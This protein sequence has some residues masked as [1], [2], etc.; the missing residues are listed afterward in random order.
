MESANSG[1]YDYTVGHAKLYGSLAIEGTT[2]QIGFDAVRELLGDI[3]GQVFLD[4]GCGTGR[5]AAF[6]K[7]LGARHV[8]GVDHDQ[9]MISQAQSRELGGVTLMHIDGP[10]PLADA[11]VDGAVSLNVFMEMRTL[12][13]MTRACTEIART[14]RPGSPLIV[15]STSP[16][17]FGHVFRN[18][19]YPVVGPLHSGDTTPCIV[20]TP[21]GQLTIEDTYWTEDDYTGALV[22]AGLT[23]TTITYPLPPDPSAW[24]TDEASIPPCVVIKAMKAA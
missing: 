18:Y 20:T 14:L 7:A 17:A 23:V 16:V 21:A 6:L 5:S 24:S 11:S 9:N 19:S 3:R 4:F 15:E 10:I 2:Y 8:Y 12:S 1:R 22:Q 13:Q